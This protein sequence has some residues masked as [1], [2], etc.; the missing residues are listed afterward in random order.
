[1]FLQVFVA[2]VHYVMSLKSNI[3]NLKFLLSDIST[4]SFKD[5][6]DNMVETLKTPRPQNGGTML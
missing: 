5:N 3:L 2:L 1:M 4:L 6:P